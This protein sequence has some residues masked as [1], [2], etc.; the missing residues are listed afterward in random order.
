[1]R[2]SKALLGALLIVIVIQIVIGGARLEAVFE[3]GVIVGAGL[4]SR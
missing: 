4:L 1:M 2:V 3:A